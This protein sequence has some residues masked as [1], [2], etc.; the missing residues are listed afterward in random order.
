M[1]L[2]R[3]PARNTYNL[4][5]EAARLDARFLSLTF[6]VLGI[7]FAALGDRTHFDAIQRRD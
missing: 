3:F 7:S 4:G 6:E 2:S 5:N 1:P